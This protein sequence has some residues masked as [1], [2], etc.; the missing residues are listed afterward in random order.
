MKRFYTAIMVAIMCTAAWADSP[1]TSTTDLA[2]AY[3]DHPMVQLALQ[4]SGQQNPDLPEALLDFITD[5]KAPVDE[6]F[7]A[8]SAIGW[9]F[10]GNGVAPLIKKRLMSRYKINDDS[11]L[12]KKLD[13][14]TLA[15][16]AY[17]V[18]LSDYFDVADAQQLAHDA[19]KKNNDRSFCVALIAALIDT[20]EYLDDDWSKI[21]PTIHNVVYDGTLRIDI[22]QYALNYIRRYINLYGE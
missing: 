20:Q 6:R 16:Y 19:L 14:K 11:K 5:N 1:L 21:H 15:V 8:V 2:Q 18:A 3:A 13:A 12:S 7:A 4:F 22:N 10:D 17:A 9:N